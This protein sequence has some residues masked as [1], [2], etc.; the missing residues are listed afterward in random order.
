MKIAIIAHPNSKNPRIERDLLGNLHVWVKE[1]PLE[2]NANRAIEDALADHFKIKRS[3]V[4][5]ISGAKS[6]NKIF[7]LATLNSA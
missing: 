2:G 5:L 7:E 1:P 3:Q 6:K 4:E